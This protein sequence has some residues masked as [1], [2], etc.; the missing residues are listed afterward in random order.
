MKGLR[1]TAVT[2]IAALLLVTMAPLAA[3]AQSASE[4]GAPPEQHYDQVVVLVLNKLGAGGEVDKFEKA[5]IAPHAAVILAAIAKISSQPV[6]EMIGLSRG[7]KTPQEI[8]EKVGADW[9]KVQETVAEALGFKR[10]NTARLQER[11]AKLKEKL[12][13]AQERY[14]KLL[15]EQA[16]HEQRIADARAKLGEITN[17]RARYW[18]EQRI[19]AMEMGLPIIKLQI[20]RNQFVTDM[21]QKMITELEAELNK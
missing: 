4:Q 2:L 13:Q 6:D 5:G 15:Q 21:L 19:T 12:A 8:A 20:E 3:A 1:K 16:N 17:E 11:L 18:A 10:D 7:G 14:Q 9:K